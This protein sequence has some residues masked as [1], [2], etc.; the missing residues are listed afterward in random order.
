MAKNDQ[1]EAYEKV[2]TANLTRII[3]FLKFAET[4]NA[5]LLTFS[6][7][8]TLGCLNLLSKP[9]QLPNGLRSTLPFAV[10]FF[11]LAALI[12]IVS[13]LPKKKLDIFH[14]DPERSRS[15]LFFGDIASFEPTAYNARVRDRY[16]PPEGASASESLLD[17]LAVQCAVIS[18]IADRKFAMFNIGAALCFAAMLTIS[19][20]TLSTVAVA[21]WQAIAKID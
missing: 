13:F 11:A 17:D 21:A 2:L 1:Q 16:M 8:W 12:A 9:E 5:A 15:L 10:I 20:P 19:M 7:A 6:S 4:K 14:R 3:D 18:R